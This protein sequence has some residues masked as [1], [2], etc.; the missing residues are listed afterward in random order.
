MS[1]T[2]RN[3]DNVGSLE[4]KKIFEPAKEIDLAK[5]PESRMNLEELEIAIRRKAAASRI[6]AANRPTPV[7]DISELNRYRKRLGLTRSQFAKKVRISLDTARGLE[8]GS[9][10]S[11]RVIRR[12]EENLGIT[13]TQKV[14]D[15]RAV[16]WPKAWWSR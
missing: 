13:I 3:N 1:E 8:M 12:I 15:E 9:Y 7:V 11:N 14:Y 10:P 4:N 5:N 6:N 2:T 16:E